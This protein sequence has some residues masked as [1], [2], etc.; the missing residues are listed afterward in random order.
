MVR[1]PVNCVDHR[2]GFTSE[3]IV[4]AFCDETAYDGGRVAPVNGVVGE[5]TIDTLYSQSLVHGLNDVAANSEIA[6]RRFS[7]NVDDPLGRSRI[8][9]KTHAFKALEPSYHKAA[10]L[11]IGETRLRFNRFDGPQVDEACFIR[12]AS[13]TASSWVQRSASTSRSRTVRISCSGL[14]QA[15]GLRVPAPERECRG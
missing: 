2:I 7:V 8:C 5:G 9:G 4:Q 3:F 10:D 14:A 12:R 11:W 15:P 13:R 1:A 6:K